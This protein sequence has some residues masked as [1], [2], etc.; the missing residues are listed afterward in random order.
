[1]VYTFYHNFSVKRFQVFIFDNY[2]TNAVTTTG[3]LKLPK[4]CLTE[5]FADEGCVELLLPR[6][7][8]LGIYCYALVAHLVYTHNE[9]IDL[10]SEIVVT[11]TSSQWRHTH[12][13]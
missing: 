3:F 9:F 4:E 2:Y 6:P 11:N 1:M 10:C 7:C 12:H 13:W 5:T 8:G